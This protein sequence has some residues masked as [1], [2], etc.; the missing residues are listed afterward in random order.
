MTANTILADDNPAT[1][2]ALAFIL[3]R[4]LGLH[5]VGEAASTN[6]LVRL[7]REGE[8]DAGLVIL[9]WDLPGLNPDH[10]LTGLRMLNPHIRI[11]VMSAR[12]DA[13]KES[14][15][16]GADAFVSMVEPPEMLLSTIFTIAGRDE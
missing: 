8:Q 6:E 16:A 12:A 14:L 5:I 15:A 11:I 10:V 7:L 3:T 13:R 2:S 1:R 4:R 9:D